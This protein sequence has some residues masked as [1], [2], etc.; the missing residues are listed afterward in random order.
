MR[1]DILIDIDTADIIENKK[2]YRFNDLIQTDREPDMS[3]NKLYF[4]VYISSINNGI[5]RF[6]MPYIPS[7]KVASIRLHINGNI[8]TNQ[9]DGGYWFDIFSDNKPIFVCAYGLIS[10]SFEFIGYINQDTGVIDLYD[11]NELDFSVDSTLYQDSY[12]IM[13]LGKGEYLKEPTLGVGMMKY[14]NGS[15]SSDY[16]SRDV[17][18]ELNIDKIKTKSIFIE[19]TGEVVIDVEE[20]KND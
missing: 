19:S 4:D 2:S 10:K 6:K 16:I 5:F 15:Q 3:V 1:N 13:K 18:A 17:V 8:I 12:L 20:D 7:E 9:F 14:I 11:S